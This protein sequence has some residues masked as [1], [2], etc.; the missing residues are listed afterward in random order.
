MPRF[1]GGNERELMTAVVAKTGPIHP[2][3]MGPKVVPSASLPTI[4][5][6]RNCITVRSLL[7]HTAHIGCDNPMEVPIPALR[8]I[9]AMPVQAV[10]GRIREKLSGGR[11]AIIHCT[12]RCKCAWA[13]QRDE[14]CFRRCRRLKPPALP[15]TYT[16]GGAAR[17][18]SRCCHEDGKICLPN[19][20]R[21]GSA[22]LHC[23]SPYWE[24]GSHFETTGRVSRL[25]EQ[26]SLNDCC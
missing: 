3:L 19:G 22:F 15:H 21:L 5:Y 7:P 4:N 6:C 23:P 10:E 12:Q 26:F 20:N 16:N 9:R 18:R 17:P 14:S 8:R 25:H 2:D 11:N 13:T 24:P 1:F